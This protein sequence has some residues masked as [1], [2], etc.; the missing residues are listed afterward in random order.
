MRQ[1]I[2]SF[3]HRFHRDQSGQ[4]LVMSA[5][6]LTGFLGMCA[7]VADVGDIYYANNQLQAATQAAALAGAE[8]I[9]N[10]NLITPGGTS[11]SETPQDFAVYYGS[12][13]GKTGGVN[14]FPILASEGT[15]VS[16]TVYLSCNTFAQS[17]GISCISYNGGATTC[18]T[19]GAGCANAIQVVQVAEVKTYFAGLFGHPYVTLTATAS[20]ARAGAPGTPYNVAIVVDSTQSM[21]D[22]DSNCSF[23]SMSRFQCALDGVQI[24]LQ[25]MAPCYSDEGSCGTASNGL[26][27]TSVDRVALFTFPNM[28]TATIPDE[29]CD[30]G[31][32]DTTCAGSGTPGG[33]CLNSKGSI[34]VLGYTYPSSTGTSY[35]PINDGAT[36]VSYAVTNGLGGTDA[37]GFVNDYKTSDGTT[38]LSSASDLIKAIGTTSTSTADMAAEGGAATYYAGVIYAAEAALYQEQQANSGSQNVL[39]ILSDGD[40][41]ATTAGML[42]SNNGY[43][44][45]TT[46][47]KYPST[48]DQCQQA[49]TAA[50]G[51]LGSNWTP[52]TSAFTTAR[53]SI[54]RVYTIAYGAEASTTCTGDTYTPCQTMKEMASNSG[55]FY[56]DNNQSGTSNDST[57]V[58][59][60]ATTS[61]ATIF[62]DI[63]TD[64]SVGRLIPNSEFPTP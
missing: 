48:K 62:S 35:S 54:G 40:A 7:M 5:L 13:T 39:I 46:S 58:G 14:T 28:S 34:C 16:T 18:G 30:G 26:T 8:A 60:G 64:F 21:T 29:Y 56:S 27:G 36:P 51:T 55:Y 53:A 15:N 50:G 43:T 17:L 42:A 32:K 47:G 24:L 19:S 2:K 4:V 23:G 45:S 41:S 20:A 3:L 37:Y 52:N 6:L 61:M 22:N 1:H 63:A 57:C 12:E 25:S 38:N 10:P 33:T 49:V 59:T 44:L 31:A 11:G 9:S